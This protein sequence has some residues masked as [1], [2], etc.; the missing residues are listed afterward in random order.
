MS[1]IVTLLAS[2]SVR[3]AASTATKPTS[4]PAG[5]SK[6]HTN[7]FLAVLLGSLSTWAA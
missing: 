1:A 6:P 2:K 5:Q 3:L 4:T 7:R